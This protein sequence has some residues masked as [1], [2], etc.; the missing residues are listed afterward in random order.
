MKRIYFIIPFIIVGCSNQPSMPDYAYPDGHS[1]SNMYSLAE[2]KDNKQREVYQN[3]RRSKEVFHLSRKSYDFQNGFHSGCE[4]GKGNYSKNR[5][6]FNSNS[7][8]NEGWFLGVAQC[9]T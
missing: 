2:I 6:L 4:T 5:E 8:Y 9:R 3:T 1:G 7:Q